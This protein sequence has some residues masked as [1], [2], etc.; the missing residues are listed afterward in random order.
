MMKLEENLIMNEI[1]NVGMKQFFSSSIVVDLRSF[2]YTMNLMHFCVHR[3]QLHNFPI[4]KVHFMHSFGVLLRPFSSTKYVDPIPDCMNTE[5]TT[6][7][8]NRIWYL[9]KAMNELIETQNKCLTNQ[10]YDLPM[11]DL[12]VI[13]FNRCKT[14]ISFFKTSNHIN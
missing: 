5:P 1:L 2:G 6:R 4:F 8:I 11:V 12:C 9:N 3:F 13:F 7:H 14:I 10:S